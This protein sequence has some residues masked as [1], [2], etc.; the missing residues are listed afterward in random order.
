MEEACPSPTGMFKRG[1][2]FIQVGVQPPGIP[3]LEAILWSNGAGGWGGARG[4][5]PFCSKEHL[6][7]QACLL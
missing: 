5:D 1:V 3:H 6:C 4:F 7:P 2:K